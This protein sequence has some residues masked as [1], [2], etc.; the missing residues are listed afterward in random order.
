[1]DEDPKRYWL[2]EIEVSEYGKPSEFY[3]FLH[4]NSYNVKEE[5]ASYRADRRY[6]LFS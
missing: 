4:E 1:M 3:Y 5:I 6:R 2:W